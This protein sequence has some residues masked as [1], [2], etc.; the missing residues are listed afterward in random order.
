MSSPSNRA[1]LVGLFLLVLAFHLTIAW[2]D[3][4]VLAKNGFLYD[5]SFYAFKI[6]QNIASGQGPTFDGVQ[7]TNGFQPLYVMLLVPVYWITG[8]DLITPVYIALTLSALFTAL[9]AMLLFVILRR[10]V[11]ARV[12]ALMTL[13]WSFSPVVTRQAANGLETSLALLMFASVV[14]VYIAR[15]RSNENPRG[16]DFALMG[17]LVGLAVLA[18][19]DEIFL[20]LV[21][22]LDYLL[23]LRKRHVSGA[24]ALRRIGVAVIVALLVYSPWLIYSVTNVGTILQDSGSATRFLSIAYAP[25]FNLGSTEMLDSGPNSKFLWGHLVH[26][27]S[28]MKVTPPVHVVFRC[29]EKL[30]VATGAGG[31]LQKIGSALGLLALGA[32][33]LVYVRKRHALPKGIEEI[34]FLGLFSLAL[35]ASY[36]LYVFGVFFFI[37][38]YYPVYFVLCIYGAFFVEA[39]SDRLPRITPRVR[40]LAAAGAAVYIIAFGMLT[41]SSAYRSV[42]VYYFFDVARWVDQNIEPDETIGVFQGGAVGYL[43]HRKVINLDGKVNRKALSALKSGELASYIEAENVDVVMD[44]SNVLRLFLRDADPVRARRVGYNQIMHGRRDGVPGWTAYRLQHGTV[45]GGGAA[46]RS[47]NGAS[48]SR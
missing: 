10:Y 8:S 29:I 25:F 44:N 23:V 43:S 45:P 46:F 13:L 7:N 27:L 40:H 14:L 1:I 22:T 4:D 48:D 31:V 42:T 41:Y 38:Y 21:I 39:L 32:M 3:F 28:V 16:R 24:L 35:I 26:S 19:V 5:D 9:T 47:P 17:A 30:D 33:A 6:A 11:S 36:S 12:A 2:Q 15:I 34:R 18:R 37:R 20:G